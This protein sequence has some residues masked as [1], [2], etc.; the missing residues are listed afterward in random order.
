MEKA[1]DAFRTIGEVSDLLETPAHV[2]RFWESRFPQIKPVKRTG[3]RRYYRPNDV[4]LLA[5][6]R[7]LLHEQGMTIKGVQKV[8]REQGVRYVAGIGDTSLGLS[9]EAV[10]HEA[11]SADLQNV[12]AE[13]SALRPTV[14]PLAEV[15]PLGSVGQRPAAHGT[16]QDLFVSLPA[17]QDAQAPDPAEPDPGEL[18]ARGE[19]DVHPSD[20]DAA[21]P[22]SVEPQAQAAPREVALPDLPAEPD[23]AL[24]PTPRASRLRGQGLR[25]RQVEDLARLAALR[26]RLVGLRDRMVEAAGRRS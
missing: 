1:P 21:P 20:A 8:L 12:L 25:M 11:D 26:E 9:R 15:I 5:G 10:E 7:L 18:D 17:E 3:G 22:P 24:L 2:L 16:Q 14:P 19:S 23:G 6:L 4:A 13:I